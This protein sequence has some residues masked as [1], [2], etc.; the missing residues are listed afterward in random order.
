MSLLLLLLVKKKEPYLVLYMYIRD[1]LASVLI[2][3]VMFG[4]VKIGQFLSG[5]L[6][7]SPNEFLL[8][9]N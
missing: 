4:M 9:K 3:R 8:M 2:T 5:N 6:F 1:F 7:I